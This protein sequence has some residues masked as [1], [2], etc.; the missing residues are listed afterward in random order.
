MSLV[1]V[2]SIPHKNLNLTHAY[3]LLLEYYYVACRKENCGDKTLKIVLKELKKNNLGCIKFVEWKVDNCEQAGSP[4]ELESSE[5][6]EQAGS[7][8]ELESSEDCEQAGSSAESE[9]SEDCEQ[10]RSSK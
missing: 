4:I 8:A 1:T 10:A 7:S 9:S 5:D 2:L 6:C 3:Y